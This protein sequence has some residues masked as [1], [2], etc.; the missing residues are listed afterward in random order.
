MID[1]AEDVFSG[2]EILIFGLGVLVWA[3][4]Q[5]AVAKYKGLCPDKKILICIPQRKDKLAIDTAEEV[6]SGLEILI[7]G[8]V[9]FQIRPNGEG[10]TVRRRV[11]VHTFRRLLCGAFVS[12]NLQFAAVK[13]KGL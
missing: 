7:F 5:S 4:L 6:F 1:T 9:G 3:D 10:R 12:A 8:L 2:L 11:S 13:Y